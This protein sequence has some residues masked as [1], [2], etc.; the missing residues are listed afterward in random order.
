MAENK[1]IVIKKPHEGGQDAFVRSSVDVC[2]FGGSLGGGKCQ[3][4]DSQVCTP[5]GF[6][7][8]GDL[9][10]GSIISRVNGRF[11]KVIAVYEKGEREVIELH[12]AD[13][14]KAECC[15]EHLWNVRRG[16]YA[17]KRYKKSGDYGDLWEVMTCEQ[18]ITYLDTHKQRIYIPNCGDIAFTK[19]SR[20]ALKINPYVL[21]ILIGDGCL[22]SKKDYP[23]FASV[24][25][26]VIERV[27]SIYPN[28]VKRA[29]HSI[30]YDIKDKTLKNELKRAG[31]WGHLA[32]SKFIPKEYLLGS[33]SNR[34]E[35]MRG[36]FDSDGYIDERGHIEYTT[37]SKQLA[38][39]VSFLVRS[40]G[41]LCTT[42]SRTGKY[43]GEDGNII[44]CQTSFRLY[45]RLSRASRFFYLSRKKNRANDKIHIG[46]D[47][48]E[49]AI[50]GYKRTGRKVAM[51]CIKVSSPDNLYITNDFIV[52]HN[53]GGSILAVAEPSLDPRFRAIFLRRTLGELKT[54][55]GIVD[56]FENMYGNNVAITKSEN[57]RITFKHSGAWI[58]C[59]QVAD[60]NPNK[61][62]ETF[63][64]LQADAIFFDELTGFEFYTWNYLMSRCRGMASWTGKIRATTNPSKKHWVR[65]MLNWYIGPDGYVIP[66]RSG[67]VRYFYL[68]GN[69]VDDYVWG[70]TKEEVYLKCKPS[71]DKSLRKLG[72][73]TTYE[74]LIKSF[75]FILGSLA[76][77]TTLLKQNPDYVGS[78]SGTEGAA[79][80]EGNWNV[81]LDELDDMPI[82]MS[83][84]RAVSENDPVTNGDR[85]ITADLGYE[86]YDNTVILA[87]D[88]FHIVD[89]KI[90][91]K[92]TTKSNAKA[93]HEMARKWD[94][95]D[96]HII[97]DAIGSYSILD[98]IPDA[99]PYKSSLG[100]QGLYRNSFERLKD[101]V[102][103]RLVEAVNDGRF[104]MSEDVA[105]TDYTHQ[106]LKS[107]IKVI[108]EFA[109][110]CSV[111]RFSTMG[112]GK[113]KLESK[114]AMNAMLG[115]SRSMDLLDP[116]AMRFFPCIN[117]EY[118]SELGYGT[119]SGT[120][121]EEVYGGV[122]IF[123]DSFWC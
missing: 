119:T 69:S 68:D 44:E 112:S 110:E 17:N 88:G 113:K 31:L 99:V 3:P 81:D 11:Q 56:E 85:W 76:E 75:T 40:F 94:V 77:N 118:G 121:D 83:K 65:K 30:S 102:Y 46:D 5:F 123:D 74:H 122:N 34:I 63:K 100:A 38:E 6:R 16:G 15:S 64:G 12:F 92:A 45:I 91:E 55:G 28:I 108:T 96:S 106:K 54:A 71:I 21:G 20:N 37:V 73:S 97:F 107:T 86:G 84:A 19:S 120:E 23:D 98:Y 59:R 95:G 39:D 33:I 4:V 89:I 66:E 51:R 78:V 14:R 47:N 9:K 52:T 90:L 116:C 27:K 87:W 79:L 62:R 26:E 57:P 93:L 8:L 82:Q 103:M 48:F 115:K 36:L 117:C 101:E 41:G 22:S 18:V 2:I 7:R 111:V 42:T 109:E 32:D 67:V 35:L 29:T 58:E 53:T 1:D 80:L 104:S 13:G 70:D 114:K 49:T 43:R 24:D 10:V 105:N 25:E 61:V 50:I 72:G 60:E